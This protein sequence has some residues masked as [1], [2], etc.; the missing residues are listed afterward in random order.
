MRTKYLLYSKEQT[1]C[2]FDFRLIVIRPCSSKR[3]LKQTNVNTFDISIVLMVIRC[4]NDQGRR[5][6]GTTG[7][8]APAAAASGA[9]LRGY[10]LF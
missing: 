8:V 6:G 7:A 10:K 9:P 3:I 4:S 1:I 2:D 5:V